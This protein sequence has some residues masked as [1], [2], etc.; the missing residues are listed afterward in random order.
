MK[1]TFLIII[2][3]VVAMYAQAQSDGIVMNMTQVASGDWLL[4]V[5]L[6]NPNTRTYSAFQ[7]DLQAPDG[8]VFI[9]STL[10]A[11]ERA[12]ALTLSTS[13]TAA[14]QR[15]VG[16]G[17]RT[18]STITDTAGVLFTITLRTAQALTAGNY[19]IVA[20][21]VRF[22]LRTGAERVLPGMV[23]TFTVFDGDT[24]VI[25]W[26]SQDQVFRSQR[27]AV[28]D[29]ITAAGEPAARE[30][31]TFQGWTEM[32]AVMPDSSVN[33]YAQW[34]RNV[35][36]V[37]YVV[38]SLTVR[39]D[40]VAYGDTLVLYDYTPGDTVHYSFSGWEGE[41]IATMPAHDLT[42]TGSL[43]L[44]GDVNHDGVVN[45]ADVVGIYNY[46]NVGEESGITLDDADLNGD[47]VVNSS[48]VTAL[49]NLIAS[50][51][52]LSSPVVRKALI[53]AWLR[54]VFEL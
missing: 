18:L 10:T 46:I 28:G 45:S 19:D 50:E 53:R 39:V 20:K 47:G 12:S 13:A 41:E 5:E 11:G 35:Y 30:G 37:N 4:T 29:S 24:Y 22:S 43:L 3:V 9:D 15:V 32:P 16:Y 54:N 40:S 44:L 14:G 36:A 51:P 7:M 31:Y 52:A 6:N 48:D 23:S 27:L 33:I 8:L 38:D 17:A 26:W 1:K 34:Q 49:Y 2:S 21:N 25:T 42:Y